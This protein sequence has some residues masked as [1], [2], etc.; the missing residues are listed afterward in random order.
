MKTPGVINHYVPLKLI[1]LSEWRVAMVVG[2]V[3]GSTLT[4]WLRPGQTKS[5]KTTRRRHNF[6]N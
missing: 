6:P 2:A 3:S 5:N 1:Q 4:V